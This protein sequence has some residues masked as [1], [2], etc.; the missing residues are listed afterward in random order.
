MQNNTRST[1]YTQVLK[2]NEDERFLEDA[3]CSLLLFHLGGNF[4]CLWVLCS[5]W[6]WVND[7]GVE[8]FFSLWSGLSLHE[9]GVLP[10]ALPRGSPLQLSWELDPVHASPAVPSVVGDEVEHRLLHLLAPIPVLAFSS[11]FFLSKSVSWTLS[12]HDFVSEVECFFSRVEVVIWNSNSK[13]K[14]SWL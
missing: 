5:G 12:L 10:V 3:C 14:L 1:H 6:Y 4:N 11:V 13:Y 8:S 7:E 9:P 2:S